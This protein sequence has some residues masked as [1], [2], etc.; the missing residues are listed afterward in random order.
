MGKVDKHSGCLRVAH[1]LTLATMLSCSCAP[2]FKHPLPAP[3][4]LKPDRTV[5][6]LWFRKTQNDRQ[7]LS[8]F[9][10]KDGWVDIVYIYDIESRTSADGIN[11]LVFEGYTTSAAE[12]K[13]MCFRLREK[14]LHA[15]KQDWEDQRAFLI[16]NYSVSKSGDLTI[17]HLSTER[18]ADLV[19]D[20][21][22]K[23][24]VAEDEITDGAFN[25]GV[26]VLS[27]SEE[28]LD[29]VRREGPDTLLGDS[30]SDTMVFHRTKTD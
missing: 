4:N 12:R 27:S 19:N 7:Q 9:P 13:F 26:V 28:L 22:L 21:R 1:L 11:V 2:R 5:S 29:V 6:G 24:D 25:E 10:R 3:E 23:G 20:G 15:L 30:V 18:V 14:D 17:R 8:V 16:V